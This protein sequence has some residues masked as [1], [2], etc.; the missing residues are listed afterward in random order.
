M[1]I[2]TRSGTSTKSIIIIRLIAIF[3]AILVSSIFIGF[4]GYNPFT[5]YTNMLKGSLGTVVRFRATLLEMIPLVITSLGILIAFKMKFWNIG[6]EGQILM[7]A[8]GASL[9]ALRI[10][11]IPPFMMLPLVFIAGFLFGGLWAFIPAFFKARFGANETILT[12]MLNYIALQFIT[13][14]QFGPW[15]D[16]KAMGFP[17]I[18][19]FPD[20]AILPKV[21]GVHMGWIVALL[22]VVLVTW[23]MKKTKKGFEIAVVGE[24][25]ATARYAG[26]NV[27][28]VILFATLISGGLCG[29][30]GVIQTAGVNK[31]LT[32][33]ISS[34]YG[35][36]AIITTWLS[37]LSAPLVVVVSFLF[38]IL[39]QGGSYIQSALQIPSSAAEVLQG[40]ILFCILGSEFFV[41]YKV[42]FRKKEKN[43]VGGSAV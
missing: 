42:R 4:L 37:G 21:F 39:L 41:R 26:M 16:P 6:G 29:I 3:A 23:F 35:F 18:A 32:M 25:V 1:Q 27:S 7:G 43:T 30:T 8:F 11:G 33:N 9:V 19:T 14:L 2:I 36:S 31:T 24:S 34:G 5:V 12:L 40:M 13:Y 10:Q 28:Q 38:A 17:K 15:R 20:S 22:L